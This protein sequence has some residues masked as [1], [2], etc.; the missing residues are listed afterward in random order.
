MPAHSR[1]LSERYLAGELA[2][3]FQ[4][5]PGDLDAAVSR[6]LDRPR[7]EVAA[8]LRAE[9]ERLRAPRQV[10]EAL[11]RLAHPRSRVVVTG[12]QPGLLVGPAYTLSKALSAIALARELDSD[13]APVVPVFW[14]AS[15]DHDTGEV[16]HAYLLDGQEQ[17]QRLALD[18]PAA[19][20]FGRIP[21][22]AEWTLRICR[23][24][25]AVAGRPE[26]LEEALK[27]VTGAATSAQSYADFCSALLYALLGEQGLVILDPTRPGVA[28][29]FCGV[30]ERELQSPLAS[31][32]AIN[33]AGER[34]RGVG[35]E[36]QLGRGREATNLFIEEE[37]DGLP[38]RELLRFDGKEFRTS[39][40]SYERNE[41]AAIIREQP[42]RV[43]PAAGLR[44]VTQDAVLPTAAFVVGPGELA[45]LAQLRGVYELHDVEMP[46]VWPRA[47]VVVLEPPVKRILGRY[48]LA[49]DEYATAP[50]EVLRRVL[51]ELTGHAESFEAAL[52]RLA[53]E[54][55]SLN[56][57]VAAI[58]PT[59][60]GTVERSRM[61]LERTIELLREKTAGALMRRDGTTRRQFSRLEAH[62][63]PAG[64]PQERVLSPFSFFLKFGSGPMMELY[65]T[66]GASGEHE[67]AP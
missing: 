51:L 55:E 12:Q 23:G 11:D 54:I 45:Y 17:L 29:F 34:L 49:Y 63:F 59:L 18:L 62:L 9:A 64:R 57:H 19:V 28:P 10:E 15:Q 52:E 14:N 42:G 31:T 21:F 6:R 53:A 33:E 30:L 2:P 43:T 65:R 37:T 27:L 7:Q 58:D 4:L 46:L 44:P 32:V 13:E 1:P 20:P 24:L 60:E 40:R 3:F 50:E 61:R 67:L 56:R 26:H 16:D 25:K 66:V 5:P 39:H 38:R 48:G 35:L 22:E 47:S 8:A 36:P 41:L